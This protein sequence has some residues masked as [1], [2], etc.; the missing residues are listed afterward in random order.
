MLD[1]GCHVYHQYAGCFPYADDV[2]SIS[3]S[4]IGLSQILVVCSVTAKSF[5]FKFNGNKSHSLSLGEVVNVDIGPVIRQSIYIAWWYSIKYH[6]VH[7]LSGKGLSFDIAPIKMA[8]YDT[9]NT[10]FFLVILM[11]SSSCL[12]KKHIACQFCYMLHLLFTW[13][14]SNNR[15]WTFAGISFIYKT[16]FAT[17]AAILYNNW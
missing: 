17:K 10:I 1:V 3:P 11:N 14:I 9:C 7:L 6:C 16:L 8:F 12:F 5:A 2:V 13:N 15:S 4:I